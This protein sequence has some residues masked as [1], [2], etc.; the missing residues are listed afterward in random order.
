MRAVATTVLPIAVFW[1]VYAVVMAWRDAPVFLSMFDGIGAELPL[2]TRALLSTYRWWFVVPL[3]F[4]VAAAGVI[5]RPAYAVAAT[6]ASLVVG[7]VM[8]AWLYH[9]L[10]AP[11]LQVIKAVQ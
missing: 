9:G 6:A 3:L 10:V 11:T 5:R 1:Q 4:T 2:V 7:C 8:H